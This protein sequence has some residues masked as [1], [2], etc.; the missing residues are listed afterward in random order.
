MLF[1]DM[2]I[3]RI[4]IKN[5]VPQSDLSHDDLGESC[6]MQMESQPAGSMDEAAINSVLK[7]EMDKIN[8][9]LAKIT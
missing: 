5:P 7:V 4:G 8:N 3:S 2:H 6:M 1:S 9:S